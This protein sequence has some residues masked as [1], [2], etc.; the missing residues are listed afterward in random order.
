MKAFLLAAGK[1]ARLKPYTDH[2]PKC[3][4]PIYGRPLLEIWFDLLV[5][6]GIT[7]VLVNTHHQAK[8]VAQFIEKKRSGT[9]LKI[10][11][12]YERELL[13]SA[14][15]LLANR[16]FVADSNDFIIAYA[17]NLTDIDLVS[18]IDFHRKC[19]SRG[20]VLTMGLFHAPDPRAC[21]IALLDEDKRIIDFREKP[22]NPM[23]NMA[24]SGIYVASQNVFDFFPKWEKRRDIVFD[25]GL[26][27]LPALIGKMHGYK[28][29]EYLRD[30]GTIE[31]YNRALEEWPLKERKTRT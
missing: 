27:V 13:G 3:L 4:I 2:N 23:S 14:G 18:M 9:Q 22:Q 17:D 20:N 21:G 5:R 10:L 6:N 30:I 12:S 16:D 11:S 29:R 28:I 7:E 1:G 8:K 31:S 24:N 26:H 25:L 19:K 15:T